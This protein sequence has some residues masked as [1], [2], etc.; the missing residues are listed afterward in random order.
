MENYLKETYFFDYSDDSIQSLIEGLESLSLHEKISTLF[1]KI[2]DSW[3]YNPYA[4]Y[5]RPEKYRASFLASQE[6]GHCI[7]KSTLFIAGLRALGIP[8]RP[9]LAKVVNH[10]AV[11][12]LTEK[13]GT[14]YLAPHGIVDVFVND[15][16]LKASNAFNKSLCDLYNVNALYFD[17]TEDAV[18]QAYNR[19]E[20]KYMEYIEDYG[21][22]EDLPFDFIMETFRTNY[23]Q[24]LEK[25]DKQNDKFII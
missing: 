11:E 21:H 15:Q 6:E 1:L 7:D 13:L 9:R 4:I 22:F 17:G 10:I 2:R 23:P 3:R 12:R 19:N 24:L 25:I 14:H 5:T 20:E 18:L 8:A 16:W